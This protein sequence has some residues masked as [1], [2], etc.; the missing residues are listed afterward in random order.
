MHLGIL[1]HLQ[2]EQNLGFCPILREGLC[3]SVC[4]CKYT[5]VHA[6]V[7]MCVRLRKKQ[8]KCPKLARNIH[9]HITKSSVEMSHRKS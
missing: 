4:M 3:V 1:L 8:V 9:Q 7:Y 2:G 6:C 5:C